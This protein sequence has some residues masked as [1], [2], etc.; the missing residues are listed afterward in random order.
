MSSQFSVAITEN[1][2][3]ALKCLKSSFLKKNLWIHWIFKSNPKTKQDLHTRTLNSFFPDY[4]SFNL[5]PPVEVKS[6]ILGCYFPGY[7]IYLLWLDQ[8]IFISYT[9]KNQNNFLFLKREIN[10]NFNFF[11]TDVLNFSSKNSSHINVDKIFVALDCN[12][13]I[14]CASYNYFYIKNTKCITTRI[15]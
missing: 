11:M 6:I 3:I 9:E 5:I 13:I 12:K 15:H 10:Y 4:L 1:V 2:C 7:G 14:A 8:N